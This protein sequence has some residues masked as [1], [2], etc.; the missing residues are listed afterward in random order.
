MYTPAHRLIFFGGIA[1]AV[2]LTFLV[3]FFPWLSFRTVAPLR[4]VFIR[5]GG[6]FSIPLVANENGP[7]PTT[8]RH[9][10][11]FL[12]QR[13]PCDARVA[14]V[15]IATAAFFFPCLIC[16]RAAR[17]T[18]R[19]EMR[20][21]ETIISPESS[22][23]ATASG[24]VSSVSGSVSGRDP[25]SKVTSRRADGGRGPRQHK[26]SGSQ[27]P[28]E[29]G[30][31]LRSLAESLVRGESSA[32][33]SQRPNP[34]IEASQ[35]VQGDEIK[36]SSSCPSPSAAVLPYAAAAISLATYLFLPFSK[37][38]ESDVTRVL[39]PLLPLTLLTVA[40]GDE[41]GGGAGKVDWEWIILSNNVG[42]FR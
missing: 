42:T 2:G 13:L 6:G 40:K 30:S 14:Q 23:L 20:L 38:S 37:T 31:D 4:Q 26:R 34:E 11:A 17:E 24:L 35:R 36:V 41:W 28:S 9:L 29:A 19:I 5:A 3:I 33:P 18:V 10:S 7:S 1:L 27:T 8:A 25:S 16:F 15:A 22:R 32:L 21:A 12:H 39:F